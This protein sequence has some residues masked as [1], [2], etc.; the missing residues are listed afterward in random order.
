MLPGLAHSLSGLELFLLLAMGHFVGDFALQSDRMAVEKCRGRDHT[1]PWP[2]WLTAH[3]GVHGFLVALLTGSV[4]LGV[5]ELLMHA[6][7][8]WGKCAGYYKLGRDHTFHL[9]CKVLWAA[10]AAQVGVRLAL[11]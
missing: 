10:I 3:A 1:L 5:A 4:W 8:D 6:L 7:I 9:L 2:W 11:S